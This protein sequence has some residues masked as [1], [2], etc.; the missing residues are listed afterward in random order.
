MRPRFLIGAV[1]SAALA[2]TLAVAAPA[3]A[4]DVPSAPVISGPAS[5][6]VVAYTFAVTGRVGLTTTAIRVD[7]ASAFTFAL[8][9]PDATGRTFTAQVTVPYGRTDLQVLAG[10]GVLWSA[11]SGLRVWALGMTPA[12]D[13]MVLVDKS[14]FMLYVIRSSR[15]VEAFPIATGMRSTATPVGT[16]HLGRPV[17]PGAGGRVWGPFR[18]PLLKY[19]HV[20]VTR[21]VHRNGRHVRVRRTVHR[22]RRTAYYIHGTSDPSSIGTRASHGCVRMFNSDLRVFRTLTV[23]NQYTVIRP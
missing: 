22:M 1:V 21:I 4:A 16:F 13:R 10:D 5:S 15:V 2:A 11:Q 14:D 20:R 6:A 18:M 9:E 17:P 3:F 7:G 8:S 23:R 19:R 12:K